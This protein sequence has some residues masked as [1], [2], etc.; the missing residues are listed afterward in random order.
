MKKRYITIVTIATI[1]LCG[2]YSVVKA[3][4][5]SDLKA[6]KEQITEELN[7]ASEGLE[8]LQ[9]EIT[10]ALEAITKIEAQIIEGE[11]ALEKTE[12]QITEI[13]EEI[14]EIEEKLEYIETDYEK[15]KDAL[16]KRLVA[17]YEMGETTYL[18]VLLNSKNI[19]DFISKYYLIGEIAQYDSD[20]LDTIEREKTKIEEINNQLVVKNEKLKTMKNTQEKTLI[21]LE[22]AKTIKNSYVAEL[23]EEE[24]KAKEQIE[25]YNN[26]LN[27]IDAKM[28]IL[29]M[30]DG[31]SEFIGGEFLWPA[32][33]NTT[34]T[35]PFGMRFHP[36]LHYYRNHNGIDIGTPTGAPI[37]ASNAGTVITASYVGTYGNV[38]MI[39][40]G[41][42]VVTAYAHGSK[43]LAE[44]GQVVERGEVIMEAG[45]TGL[46][47]GPHLHFEI[48]INGTFVDPL[49]YVTGTNQE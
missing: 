3:D 5:L 30:V 40:H 12:K 2:M 47:T 48:K 20:L 38:V 29:A 35:S 28:A 22:N 11:T 33:G 14:K 4:Y 21:A 18:D 43:I 34:I 41:G 42:G 46:S 15:Q 36:I 19:T 49:P 39:D 23:T 24:L 1:V 9:I 16:Q 7:Q 10:E 13:E 26:Q 32:P 44:V 27:N 6:E 31:N 45:S 37:V 8:D 17:L 25:E